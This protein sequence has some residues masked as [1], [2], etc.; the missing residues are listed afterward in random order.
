MKW[1]AGIA[2]GPGAN[3]CAGDGR[4]RGPD[5]AASTA[6]R[7]SAAEARG[8]WQ[9]RFAVA[10]L[11]ASPKRPLSPANALAADACLALA[12]GAPPLVAAFV[13]LNHEDVDVDPALA[14]D[15]AAPDQRPVG[16]VLSG[17]SPTADPVRWAAPYLSVGMT[18]SAPARMPLGHREVMYFALV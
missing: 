14:L 2:R 10:G 12:A 5:R 3:D 11:R 6:L 4:G 15:L 18:N 16:A 7:T 17:S 13:D 1:T 9:E 8:A